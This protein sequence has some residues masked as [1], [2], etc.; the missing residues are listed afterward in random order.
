MVM[1]CQWMFIHYDKYTTLVGDDDGGGGKAGVGA[2]GKWGISVSPSQFSVN[3]K[4]L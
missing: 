4:L 1:T 3:L 2:E